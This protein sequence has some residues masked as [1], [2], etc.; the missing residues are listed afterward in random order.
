MANGDAV[1]PATVAALK[2]SAWLVFALSLTTSA[3]A[4]CALR[5]VAQVTLARSA[6]GLLIAPVRI[7]GQAAELLLDTGAER[8]VLSGEG[9]RALGLPLDQW[10]STGM[11]GVGGVERHRNAD[12]ASVTLGGLALRRRALSGVVSLPVVP[13]LSRAFGGRPLMGLLGM[14]LLSMFDLEVDPAGPSLA[15]HAVS[16]CVGRFPPWQGAYSAVPAVLPRPG[17]M[18]APVTVNGTRLR[19]LL[20]TGAATTILDARAAARLGLAEGTR[21]SA[22][23]VGPG[24]LAIRSAELAELRLGDETWTHAPAAVALLPGLGYDMVLGMDVLGTRRLWLSFATSQAF[25]A[26]GG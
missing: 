16:G 22:R 24:A 10:V 11:E 13:S 26:A 18:V 6:E 3:H 12:V 17:A 7:D 25:V 14:D 15:L 5:D 21:G 1:R 23:G 9:V 19:A 20:D 8:T 2:L 4:A